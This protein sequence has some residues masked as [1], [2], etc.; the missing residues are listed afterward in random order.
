MMEM[1]RVIC[2]ERLRFKGIGRDEGYSNKNKKRERGQH[3]KYKLKLMAL[4]FWL[5]LYVWFDSV[6][7]RFT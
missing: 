5:N 4:L 2:L 6:F 3:I 7:D 1:K